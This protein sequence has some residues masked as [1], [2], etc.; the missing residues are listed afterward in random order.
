MPVWKR[1]IHQRF[2]YFNSSYKTAADSDM[3]IRAVKGG[4]KIKMIKD[5]VG[6]YYHNPKGRST[7]SETLKGMLDEVHDMRKKHD[8][9]YEFKSHYKATSESR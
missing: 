7:D 5:I 3:W 1:S 8:P 9:T 4:A 6:I 2:G